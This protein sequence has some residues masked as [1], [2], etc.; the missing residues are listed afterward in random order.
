MMQKGVIQKEIRDNDD[1]VPLSPNLWSVELI[2]FL[3]RTS[4]QPIEHID[5]V[6]KVR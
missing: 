6:Y 1:L 5:K 3:K 2:N 4:A